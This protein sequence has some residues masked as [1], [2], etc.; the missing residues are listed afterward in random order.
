M[1][2]K[3]LPAHPFRTLGCYP[4]TGALYRGINADRCHQRD[5]FNDHLEAP[6]RAIDKDH[7]TSEIKA[8][9]IF[10]NGRHALIKFTKQMS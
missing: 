3:K 10:L 6:G 5:A 7:A 8:A 9:R 1:L 2:V 4:L